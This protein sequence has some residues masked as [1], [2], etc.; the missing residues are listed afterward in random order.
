MNHYVSITK[1]DQLFFSNCYGCQSSCCDGSRFLFLPLILEDFEEVYP[2]FPIVFAQ[3]N[4]EMRALILLIGENGTCR[5]YQSGECVIYNHRPPG[6]RL[7]PFTP[8]FED[9]LVDVSCPAVSE[10]SGQFLAAPSHINTA[11][12]HKRLIDFEAKRQ[13]T[14]EYIR[15][16]NDSFESIGEINTMVLLRYTGELND[17]YMQMHFQSLLLLKSAI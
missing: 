12:H 17:A 9:I 14:V 3:I 16:L 10:T 5:Y 8:Y 4:G 1:I 13:T 15:Q 11:F 2:Y 6:C 7:Y